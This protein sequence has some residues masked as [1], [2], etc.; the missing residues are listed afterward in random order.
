MLGEPDREGDKDG[1]RDSLALGDT[2]A[3][4]LNDIDCDGVSEGESEMLKL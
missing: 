3:L 4:S 2:L 1:E